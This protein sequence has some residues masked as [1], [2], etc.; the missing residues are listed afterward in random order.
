MPTVTDQYS[1]LP[2]KKRASRNYRFVLFESNLFDNATHPVTNNAQA[3][4]H[5]A[6]AD[7]TTQA[8]DKRIEMV[9]NKPGQI[10][11]RVPLTSTAA[12]QIVNYEIIR[13]IVVYV[14]DANGN[15]VARWSG[16][17]WN[18]ELST[19]ANS[20]NVTCVG[21]FELLNRREIRQQYIFSNIDAGV[22]ATRLLSTANL[23]NAD[24]QTVTASS[25][26]ATNVQ[27]TGYETG[28]QNAEDLLYGAGDVES[29][30]QFQTSGSAMDTGFP[31]LSTF[32]AESGAYSISLSSTNRNVSS[33]A[34]LLPPLPAAVPGTGSV[35]ETLTPVD[36]GS[37]YQVKG[38]L[39]ITT[40]SGTRYTR[41]VV[42]WY[43]ASKVFLSQTVGASQSTLGIVTVADSHL[44]PAGAAFAILFLEINTGASGALV[45]YWDALIMSKTAVDIYPTPIQIGTVSSPANA[46]G[47]NR[48][49]TYT[50]GQKIGNAIEELSQIEGGFD[51]EIALVSTAVSGPGGNSTTLIRKLN[52]TYNLVKAAT[53]IYGIGQDRPNVIFGHRWGP[54][55]VRG[56]RESHDSSKLA[57]RINGRATGKLAMAQDATS[58]ALRGI[59]EDSVSISDAN[60]AD[61][62]LLGYAGA[63]VVFRATPAKIYN[64]TPF[65]WDGDTGGRIP[66]FWIDYILGD[67][68]YLVADNGAMQIGKTGGA[69]AIRIFG[70]SISI[71][72]EGNERIDSLQTT[73]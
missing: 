8:R 26:L 31:V 4:L 23:Q 20:V 37:T 6:V 30:T 11:F 25:A 36:A 17:I 1:I 21:W 47:A 35:G 63:E 48:Y 34:K 10:T 2:V 24:V 33:Y 68:C 22:I 51:Y 14:D 29:S 46:G 49:R 57:N 15:P 43:N 18:V 62:V 73:A 27:R 42:N 56:V 19:D 32:W 66:R 50:V 72:M 7:I 71:D 44:A 3:G 5:T 9:L 64:V 40:S 13:C 41:T 53:S 39:N 54:N 61:R 59:F 12:L 55:N 70:A 16:P 60:I 65:P 38:R 52:I 45:C 28:L 58:I 69:Q 67:I